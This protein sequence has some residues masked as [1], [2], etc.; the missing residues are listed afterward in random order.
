MKLIIAY[1]PVLH[2]GYRDFFEKNK[3]AQELWILGDWLEREFKE[4]KKDIRKLDPKLVVK[5]VK[6]WGLFANQKVVGV[7]DL[8]NL[9]NPPAGGK[10]LEIIMP[11]DDIC[12]A[13]AKK[14]FPN[15][16]IKYSPVFLRWDKHRV[17]TAVEPEADKII[18]KDDFDKK[19]MVL[20]LGEASKSIDWWRQ[21]GGVIVK[22]GEVLLAGF[23]QRLPSEYES[24][25]HNDMRSLF[26][27]GK[28]IELLVSIHAEANLIAAAAKRGIKLEG[29]SMYVNLF[30]C[31]ICAKQIAGAGIKRL[32]YM[33]GYSMTDG[34]S[35]LK[36]AGVKLIRVEINEKEK[37]EL[38]KLSE[39]KSILKKY[40]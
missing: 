34:V 31:P 6:A 30:P 18:S 5:S 1:I 37:Q 28:F 15:F 4:V 9:E 38:E 12:K 22:D 29:A 33:A 19:I 16:R 11:N 32:F 10:I 3:D 13:I 21:V 27:K 23:N 26:S 17:I 35:I 24:Y 8:K 36:R 2:Q 14:Y 25:F 40:K 20:A 7:K 39:T